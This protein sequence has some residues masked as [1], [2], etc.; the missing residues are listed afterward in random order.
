MK[1]S[2]LQ[3]ELGKKHG[4]DSPE[5]E[6]SLNLA[7]TYDQIQAEFTRLFNAHGISPP[8]YNV[9][10]ILRG[11]GGDGIPCQVIGNEMITRMPDI[12]RLVDRLEKAGLVKRQRTTRDRRVVL[13]GITERGLDLLAKLDQ[14]V[15]ES[16]EQLLGHLTHKELED[17]NRLLVK[18]RQG[19]GIGE[20]RSK[21]VVH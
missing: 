4:F 21:G 8:L 11:H 19:A 14:P 20:E 1:K 6:A 9:L 10:R 16:H 15:L 3:I 17:L 7:R 18:V 2:A 13:V 12:T 5:Q